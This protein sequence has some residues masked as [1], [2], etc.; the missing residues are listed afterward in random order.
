[1]KIPGVLGTGEGK[2]DGKPCIIIFVETNVSSVKKQIP[3]ELEGYKVIFE[4]TGPIEA[5]KK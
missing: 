3:S 2:S 1:M 4:A 5:R